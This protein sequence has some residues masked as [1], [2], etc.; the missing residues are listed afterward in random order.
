MRRE[1]NGSDT[2]NERK[3]WG[4]NTIVQIANVRE[5]NKERMQWFRYPT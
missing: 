3:Q 5:Y 2:Q 4:E 1:C